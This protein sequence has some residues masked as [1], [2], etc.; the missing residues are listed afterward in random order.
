MDFKKGITFAA[1]ARRGSF[2]TK[3]AYESLDNLIEGTGANFGSQRS[4]GHCSI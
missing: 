1:F 2:E 4:S 3:E